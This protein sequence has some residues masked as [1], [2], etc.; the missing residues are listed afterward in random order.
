MRGKEKAKLKGKAMKIKPSVWIG[1]AGLSEGVLGEI[2]KQLKK[3]GLLKVKVNKCLKS[4]VD[5]IAEELEK[6]L[7]VEVV[8]V[9]GRT[10]V[11]YRVRG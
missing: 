10:I 9:K 1:K 8:E 5:E 4:K 7:K 6:K 11:L 2:E 3:K